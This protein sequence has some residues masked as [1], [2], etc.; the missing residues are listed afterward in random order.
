MYYVPIDR[1]VMWT[2]GHNKAVQID[3]IFSLYY[4]SLIKEPNA[5]GIPIA[6]TS[7]RVSLYNT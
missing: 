7:N 5:Q 6:V 3:A 1:D 4:I 2:M